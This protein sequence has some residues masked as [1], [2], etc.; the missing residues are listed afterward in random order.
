M[1]TSPLL[2]KSQAAGYLRISVRELDRRIAAGDLAVV[3]VARR[4][5][6]L[7]A[8]LDAFIDAKRVAP[9]AA[10]PRPAFRR[11]GR[12]SGPNLSVIARTR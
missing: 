11:A 10:A 3:R 2:D 8:D 9:I 5:M 1:T 7:Q 4:P 6:F 12:A